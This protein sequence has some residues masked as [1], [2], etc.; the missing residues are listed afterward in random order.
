MSSIDLSQFEMA[1]LDGTAENLSVYQGKLILVVNTAS[2][3]GFT[4]QFEGLEAL[5]KKY[6]EQG[7]V[8]LGFPC[9]QF[10]HQEP[11]DEAAIGEFCQKNY[12]VT[13]P[14][15]GKI[16]VNGADA[17]PLFKALSAAAPGVLGSKA[18]KWNFT[19]FLIAQD[20]EVLARFAPQ[21]TPESLE[22]E[23]TARLSH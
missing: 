7:F 18:I 6:A 9:N 11:G 10:A 1:R 22:K 8:V 20:G 5:H 19:K 14:M 12:G 2:K 15:F 23:I 13:F 16:D 21:A 17:A 3:C 4:G